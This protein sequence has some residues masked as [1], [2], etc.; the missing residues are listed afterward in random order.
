MVHL[1]TTFTKQN[2]PNAGNIPYMD[3]MG[4]IPNIQVRNMSHVSPASNMAISLWMF[5]QQKSLKNALNNRVFFIAQLKPQRFPLRWKEDSGRWTS[6]SHTFIKAFTHL[7]ATILGTTVGWKLY[8]E[9]CVP[10]AKKKV[11]WEPWGFYQPN[12][13]FTPLSA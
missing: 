8:H 12:K 5:K 6:P 13:H 7:E 1:F 10:L 2:Q 4:W 11:C 3:G 9:S